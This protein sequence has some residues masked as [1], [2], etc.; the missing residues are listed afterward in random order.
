VG[1][2]ICTIKTLG[3]VHIGDTI[4]HRH[5]AEDVEPLP[6]YRDPQH[7]VFCGLY[8]SN[9]ADYDLLRKALD[10]LH[11]NDCSFSY[12]PESS[13]A[14]GFG[15]RCGFLGLLHMEIVQERLERESSLD[16]VQTAPSVTYQVQLRDGQEVTIQRPSD[17][18]DDSSI[19]AWREPIV[20]VNLLAPADSIGTLMTLAEERRGTYRNTEYISA[21]RVILVYDLPLSEVI[22]DF[23]DLLKSATHGYGTMDYELLE[24]RAADLVRLRILVNGVEV[25]ALTTIMHREHATRRGRQLIEKLRREIPRHQFKV[26][27]QAAIGGRIVARV[28]IAPVRKDVLAKC[29]GGDVSRKRKLLEKQKA[30][31]RRMKT[32]GNVEIPQQAFMSVLSVDEDRNTRR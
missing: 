9:H 12:V 26:P 14:L 20:R 28:D 11:L 13:E 8:P 30:G 2:L 1:Y 16:L 21:T 18:P 23:Y 15:F 31:K 17:L 29:Y 24:Y 19:E 10:R 4:T 22:Y 7:M 27:L 6:G 5:Q 3:E 25:D 32:V